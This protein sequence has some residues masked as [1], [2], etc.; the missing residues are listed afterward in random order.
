MLRTRQKR[1]GDENVSKWLLEGG[2]FLPRA[3]HCARFAM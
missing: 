2:I 3:L 1:L